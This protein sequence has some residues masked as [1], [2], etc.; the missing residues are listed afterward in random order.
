MSILKKVA[1]YLCTCICHEG[2]GICDCSCKGTNRQWPDLS[3]ICI[4]CDGKGKKRIKGF[5]G[6]ET[7]TCLDCFNGRVTDVNLKKVT[8][9]I[10]EE[11]AH[12]IEC[13]FDEDGIDVLVTP[14]GVGKYDDYSPV[15]HG[16]TL[17]EAFCDALLALKEWKIE[18]N[19]VRVSHTL[20]CPDGGQ[21]YCNYNCLVIQQYKERLE[22]LEEQLRV[23]TQAYETQNEAV[24][25]LHITL[26]IDV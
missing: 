21:N 11:G 4:Q 24:R 19:Q 12:H 2:D 13:D 15:G 10:K 17:L 6:Q 22:D 23:M 1:E 26:G 16:E 8:R 7:H 18:N 25:N 3:I 14:A 20:G 9:V 5:L